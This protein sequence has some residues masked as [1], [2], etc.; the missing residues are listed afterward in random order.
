MSS[1]GPVAPYYDELMSVVPYDMWTDYYLLLLLQQEVEPETILDVACGTGA[2]SLRL[3]S[4]DYKVTGF[5]LSSQMIERAVQNAELYGYGINFFTADASKFKTNQKF[6]AALS[7]FDSLNY[8]TD[9]SEFHQSFKQVAMH[10]KAGGSYIFDLNTEYAFEADLFTQSEHKKSAK[11]QYDWVGDYDPQSRLIRVTMDFNYQGTE[12]REV[13]MQRAY[14][15][16]EVMDALGDAG[17]YKIQCYDAFT[18]N[19]PRRHSDRVH[20]AAIKK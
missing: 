9:P 10:L 20:Y 13:H 11:I 19:P 5:D 12:F 2:M 7:F 3:A 14:S 17:F 4:R 8:I 1:F 18:L 15:D 16:D 6:D